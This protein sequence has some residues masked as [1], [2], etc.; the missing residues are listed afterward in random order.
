[1]NEIE[2]IYVTLLTVIS[3][4]VTIHF[5]TISN[6]SLHCILQLSTGTSSSVK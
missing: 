3:K 1:M 6:N 2:G 5:E 4:Y